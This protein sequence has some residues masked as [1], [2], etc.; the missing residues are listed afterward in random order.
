MST[1]PLQQHAP[2][3]RPLVPSGLAPSSPSTPRSESSPSPSAST[4]KLFNFPQVILLLGCPFPD[5]EAQRLRVSTVTG[6][7]QRLQNESKTCA[8]ITPY[9]VLL[10]CGDDDA[11]DKYEDWDDDSMISHIVRGTPDLLTQLC[12]TIRKRAVRIISKGKGSKVLLCGFNTFGLR[13]VQVLQQVLLG[14]PP[15]STLHLGIILLS[16]SSTRFKKKLALALASHPKYD[17][18][19]VA[20]STEANQRVVTFQTQ[21]DPVIEFLGGLESSSII[22]VPR[23]QNETAVCAEILKQLF[24]GQSSL[25]AIQ[26]KLQ[27]K[28]NQYL[29]ENPQNI[30]MVDMETQTD[31][32]SVTMKQREY[33]RN[34]RIL[35]VSSLGNGHLPLPESALL[36]ASSSS[37]FSCAWQRNKLDLSPR[38]IDR[39]DGNVSP[40]LNRPNTSSTQPLLH[41]EQHN[42]N[43][44]T[45]MNDAAMHQ[46]FGW[47]GI[48]GLA[49]E[50]GHP[51]DWDRTFS[52]GFLV[53]K[54]MCAADPKMAS[55][56]DPG[57]N[58]RT[59]FSTA[60]KKHNW[61]WIDGAIS[62]VLGVTNRMKDSLSKAYPGSAVRM[63]SKLYRHYNGG[64]LLGSKGAA[65][66]ASMPNYKDTKPQSL[67][68]REQRNM[69]LRTGALEECADAKIVK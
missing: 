18:D 40:R 60:A 20:A 4:D 61:R 24:G 41:V 19:A 65:G 69:L 52:N 66:I 68:D 59:A 53:A 9:D 7:A 3:F 34:A 13:Q 1:Q 36:E 42:N 11:Q 14:G 8:M 50:V 35:H 44:V 49:S 55:S 47:F 12:L 30:T 29:G 31:G 48:L 62:R 46:L 58:M 43:V 16:A 22:S 37:K 45:S 15:E 27:V 56:I 32:P 26:A 21:Y 2:S 39:S 51:D 64:T 25:A 10:T 67:W 6:V 28:R 38:R 54:I 57:K 33:D 63:L 23:M 17:G 5:D